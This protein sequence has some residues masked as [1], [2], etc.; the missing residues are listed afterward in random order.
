MQAPD[1]AALA[2]HRSDRSGA[3][4]S[5]SDLKGTGAIRTGSRAA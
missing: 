2:P 1:P 3:A 4:G 5:A